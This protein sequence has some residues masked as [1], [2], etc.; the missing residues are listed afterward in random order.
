MILCSGQMNPILARQIDPALRARMLAF[1]AQLAT[2][3]DNVVL[4]QE[5]DLPTQTEA[6]YEDL[7]HANSAAQ[8]RFTEAIARVLQ[9]LDQPEHRPQSP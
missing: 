7:S 8:I 4:L 3:Y 6:D 2:K 9:G 1:L 5:K